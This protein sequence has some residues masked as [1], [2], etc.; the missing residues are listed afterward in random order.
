MF[1]S[2]LPFS[3]LSIL[4]HYLI[5]FVC[6]CKRFAIF[7]M[8]GSWDYIRESQCGFCYSIFISPIALTNFSTAPPGFVSPFLR[9]DDI[10]TVAIL[11]ARL[12]AF[13]CTGH[14]TSTCLIVRGI[15]S[16]HSS[17]SGGGSLV[18]R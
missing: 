18:M 12:R 13:V 4:L 7:I 1:N 10:V 3:I 5:I 15:S 2:L 14:S 6:I 16:P 11:N 17:H 9:M 8:G